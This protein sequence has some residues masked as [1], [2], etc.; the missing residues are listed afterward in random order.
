[1]N[2]YIYHQDKIIVNE[3]HIRFQENRTMAHTVWPTTEILKVGDL[4]TYIDLKLFSPKSSN[5][6]YFLT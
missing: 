1:M 5:C 6:K 3:E 4:V 2:C